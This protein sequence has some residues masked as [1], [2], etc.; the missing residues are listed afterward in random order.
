M[1]EPSEPPTLAVFRAHQQLDDR[2][3]ADIT[4]PY[5]PP[6]LRRFTDLGDGRVE[7]Q[8][9]PFVLEYPFQRTV[10]RIGPDCH[11]PDLPCPAGSRIHDTPV[12]ECGCPIGW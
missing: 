2:P 1:V 6:Q 5:Y 9:R 10:V 11:E 8:A 4:V 12:R 3:L 7:Q